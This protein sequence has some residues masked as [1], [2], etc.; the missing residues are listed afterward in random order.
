MWNKGFEVHYPRL[1]REHDN[2]FK[3]MYN[4]ENDLTKQ[5]RFD[6]LKKIMREHFYCKEAQFCD[7]HDLH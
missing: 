6:H 4:V 5:D 7:A 1:D 3:A 2:L